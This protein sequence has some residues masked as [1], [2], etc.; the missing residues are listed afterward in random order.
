MAQRTINH[1]YRTYAEAVQVMAD[2]TNYGIPAS[3]IN[4]IESEADPRLPPEVAAA[5]AQ[6][7]AGTGA[8]LGTVIGGGLGALAGIGAIT[9]PYA[10]PLLVTGWVVPTLV[11]AGIGAAIG[12]LVGTVLRLG[13]TGRKAHAIAAELSRGKQLVVVH[14]DEAYAAHVEQ[15]MIQPRAPG[16]LPEPAYDYE[17][18]PPRSTRQEVAALRQA[19]RTVQYKSE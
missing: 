13:A 12:A 4:V 6:N 9:L 14:V 18:V 5:G 7:P 11:F 8:T 15:I 16:P 19:E 17:P 3:E 2:L 1:F 10:D